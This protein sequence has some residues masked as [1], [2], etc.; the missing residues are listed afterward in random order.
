MSQ[1]LQSAC[2]VTALD[3]SDNQISDAGVRSL[4]QVLQSPA[5]KVTELE[6]WS[7]QITD[8]GR[9]CLKNMEHRKPNIELNYYNNRDKN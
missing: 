6:L 2:K 9:E 5:C 1:A 8:T 7:I 4:S 3:L